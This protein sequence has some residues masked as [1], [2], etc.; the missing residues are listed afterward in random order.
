MEQLLTNPSLMQQAGVAMASETG[1]L[2]FNFDALFSLLRGR[3]DAFAARAGGA[4]GGA[5]DA[6]A[7]AAR[8][9]LRYAQRHNAYVLL[10]GAQAAAVEAWQQLV[11][12]C[13]GGGSDGGCV[14]GRAPVLG[15]VRG[16]GGREEMGRWVWHEVSGREASEGPPGTVI[17]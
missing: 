8:A 12:V 9:A 6:A 5:A 13:R 7:D 17:L 1:D 16:E 2:I 3:L 4:V 14:A 10:A 11:Q 15:N